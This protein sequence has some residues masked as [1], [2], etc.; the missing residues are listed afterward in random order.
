MLYQK[1]K[2]KKLKKLIFIS[3]TKKSNFFK[4]NKKCPNFWRR[5]DEKIA[6]KYSVKAVRDSLFF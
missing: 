2:Y 6:K 1:K 3:K 4:M 5:Q